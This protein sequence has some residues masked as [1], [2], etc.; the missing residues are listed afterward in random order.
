MK[1]I[2]KSISF[3]KKLWR[4]FLYGNISREKAAYK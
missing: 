4:W 1:R 2:A 3:V